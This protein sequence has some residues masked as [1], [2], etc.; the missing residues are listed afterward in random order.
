MR[1]VNPNKKSGRRAVKQSAVEHIQDRYVQ[2][3]KQWAAWIGNKYNRLPLKC[4]IIILVCFVVLTGGYSIF[5][6]VSAFTDKQSLSHSV[7]HISIPRHIKTKVAGPTGNYAIHSKEYQKIHRFQM[8][9]D[10]LYKDPSG[11][12]LY[13]SIIRSRPG[14]MDSVYMVEKEF[15]KRK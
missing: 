13:N 10:S 12:L 8:Y 1:F 6:V 4:K 14:L 9:M 7:T 2:W 15:W 3:K 5:L 11:R